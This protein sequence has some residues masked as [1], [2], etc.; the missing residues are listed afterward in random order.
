LTTCS[1]FLHR[2]EKNHSSSIVREKFS[3]RNSQIAVRMNYFKVKTAGVIGNQLIPVEVE[4]VQQRR[5]PY[6]QIIGGAPGALAA[7]RERI[8]AAMESCGYRLPSRRITLS[9]S[10]AS[11]NGGADSIDL[12]LAIAVLGSCGHFST[13]RIKD[14]IVC[15]GLSLD[16][17]L[18]PVPFRAPLRRWLDARADVPAILPWDDS[19]LLGESRQGGGFLSLSQVV[20]YLKGHTA[21]GDRK[22]EEDSLASRRDE[23]FWNALAPHPVAQRI[24]QIAAAGNHSVVVSGGGEEEGKLLAETLFSLFPSP[25]VALKEEMAATHRACGEEL[26]RERPFRMVRAEQASRLLR[27]DASSGLWGD[28]SLANGGL[29]YLSALGDRPLSFVQRLQEPLETGKIR[30]YR[31]GQSVQQPADWALVA[32]VELCPCGAEG[33]GCG[34]APSDKERQGRRLD[35]VRALFQLRFHFSREIP[36]GAGES[37]GAAALRVASAVGLSAARGGPNARLS[38]EECFRVKPW[39]ADALGIWRAS[40]GMQWAGLGLSIARVAL[41]ISDLRGGLSVEKEDVLEAR[42]YSPVPFSS[43]ARSGRSLSK[44]GEP[45]RNSTAMP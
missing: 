29:L 2:S 20:A 6:L 40:S 3:V 36:V 32:K 31:A 33:R 44:F 11:S 4:C 14:F 17:K 37:F 41:T 34:C 13:E 8:M 22:R 7:Q 38:R 24:V 18:L 1:K 28:I 26:A 35:Q 16:G 25:S 45:G 23:V 21:K 27:F 9:V 12:A 10:S 43:I 5:L 30:N 15:G 39:S 19:H 42:H